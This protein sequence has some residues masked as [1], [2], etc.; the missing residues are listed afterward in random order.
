VKSKAQFDEL[1]GPISDSLHAFIRKMTSGDLDA[2]TL[3]QQTIM[4][5]YDK[6]EQ[7]E[8]GTNFK[9]WIFTIARTVF[10]NHTR[11][12]KQQPSFIYASNNNADDFLTAEFETDDLEI[13]GVQGVENFPD[14]YSALNPQQQEVVY[15]YYAMH[16]KYKEIAQ[17]LGVPIG[18]VMSRLS[19]AKKQMHKYAENSRQ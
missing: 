4:R 15:Y 11:S 16:L 14:L 6:F 17:K 7:F 1:L 10:L 2:D 19:R 3:F 12:K 18:T 5:A 8:T 9:A 13:P